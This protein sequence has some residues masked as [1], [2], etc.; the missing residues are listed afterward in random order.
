MSTSHIGGHIW[1]GEQDDSVLAV[2]LYTCYVFR[3]EQ[4]G[5]FGNNPLGG[6]IAF[7]LLGLGKINFRAEPVICFPSGN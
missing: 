6:R 1:T 7:G 2:C 5:R 3:F 4:G